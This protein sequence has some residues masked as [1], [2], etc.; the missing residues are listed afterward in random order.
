MVT[1]TMSKSKATIPISGGAKLHGDDSMRSDYEFDEGG[2]KTQIRSTRQ[3]A[4]ANR[5]AHARTALID[6]SR[7]NRSKLGGG[8]IEEFCAVKASS[9]SNRKKADAT[10][11]TRIRVK[12][13]KSKIVL[14]QRDTESR[15]PP[16]SST[17]SQHYSLMKHVDGGDS[18]VIPSLI[19]KKKERKNMQSMEDNL[20]VTFARFCGEF[21]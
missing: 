4:L 3:A 9:K 15:T 13:D 8:R 10:N 19:S 7:K 16:P 1:K 6:K 14:Q 20:E 17:S 18:T 21:V 5:S 11:T 2:S 12:K